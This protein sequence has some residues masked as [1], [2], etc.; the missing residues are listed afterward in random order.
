MLRYVVYRLLWL[1]PTL[2]AMALVTFLV[3]LPERAAL[4]GVELAHA[5]DLA[6]A[7]DMLDVVPPEHQLTEGWY[8]RASELRKRLVAEYDQYFHRD[9]E[10]ARRAYKT[11]L[12]RHRRNKAKYHG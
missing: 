7:E 9:P 4:L 3:M 11:R 12:A 8:R 6:A 10:K 2:L 1:V 5:H